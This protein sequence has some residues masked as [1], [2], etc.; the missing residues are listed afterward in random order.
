MLNMERLRAMVEKLLSQE[1]YYHSLCVQREAARL[2]TLQGADWFKASV[3]G[4]THDI[5]KC[6]SEDEQLKY[7]CSH[8][9]MLDTFTM[10]HP[11]LWHSIA[12][13]VYL[14]Y[15]LGVEDSEILSAVQYHT[16]GRANMSP[17]QLAVFLGD[18]ISEDRTYPDAEILRQM[19]E[20]DLN[21]A[22]FQALG[23]SLL[24]VLK[25]N[26]PIVRDTWE[27]WNY[28]GMLVAAKTDLEKGGLHA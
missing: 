11:S 25:K 18:C 15:E 20:Y 27:A 10:E 2:A 9:I 3:A 21:R 4:L 26:K 6:M 22:V 23:F 5:C 16:S 17:L 28:Y 13:S 12:G 19:A 1:R 14:K 7:I 8:G 24:K